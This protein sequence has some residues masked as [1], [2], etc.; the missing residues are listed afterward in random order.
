MP[1]VSA[2]VD[3]SGLNAFMLDT[4][5]LVDSEFWAHATYEAKGV[6][7]TLWMYAWRQRPPASLPDD[8]TV[9]CRITGLSAKRLQRLLDKGPASP[10]YGFEKCSDGRLYHPVLAADALRAWDR[11]TQAEASAHQRWAKHNEL[12]RIGQVVSFGLRNRRD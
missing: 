10:L 2:D 9:W 1:L 6:A 11:R 4:L 7:L 12:R 5:R 3:I 8:R